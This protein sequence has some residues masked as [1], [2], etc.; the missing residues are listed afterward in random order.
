[1]T[2]TLSPERKLAAQRALD[3]CFLAVAHHLSTPPESW[4]DQGRRMVR[5]WDLLEFSV[6]VDGNDF[7]AEF[8]ARD[9]AMSHCIV[10]ADLK[11]PIGSYNFPAALDPL[12]VEGCRATGFTPKCLPGPTGDY[13][14]RVLLRTF[15]HYVDWNALRRSVL[16]ALAPDPVVTS[17]TRRIF[18]S[19][20]ATLPNF[21][22]VAHHVRE[23][24]LVGIEHPGLLPFLRWEQPRHGSPLGNF[25]RAMAE[26]GLRP[27]ARR[28]LEQW[29]FDTFGVAIDE[30]DDYEPVDPHRFIARYANVLDDLQVEVEPCPMFSYLMTRGRALEAPDWYLRALWNECE[31]LTEEYPDDP[32]LIDFEPTSAW[33]DSRPRRPDENQRRAGWAWIVARAEEHK[34]RTDV[35]GALPWAVPCGEMA[36]GRFVVKPLG[37]RATLREEAHEMRNCLASMEADCRR[38]KLAAFSIRLEG[39]CTACFTLTQVAVARPFW[40]LL[41]VAGKSNSQVQPEIRDVA[42]QVVRSLNGH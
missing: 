2:R 36:V 20:F 38:G 7:Q 35:A 42:M 17:L 29:G 4:V 23:L 40:T 10:R 37:D 8:L 34:L 41:Q 27:S 39:R 19:R 21:N 33:I 25:E 11:G 26:E 24:S 31:S 3:H 13:M 12:L 14:R 22:W 30:C 1:M 16:Q 28:K 6:T 5:L 18:D 9:P 32:Y 15:R